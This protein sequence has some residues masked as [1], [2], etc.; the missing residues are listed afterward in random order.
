MNFL[1]HAVPYL[2]DDPVVAALTGLPDLL[3][4]VDRRVRVRRKMAVPFAQAEGVVGEVARGVMLHIDD[5]RWFHQTAAFVEL[6]MHLAVMLREHLPGDRGFRPS[7]LGHVLIEV[8]LDAMWLSDDPD[9]GRRY[10]DAVAAIDGPAVASAVGEL[11]GKPVPGLPDVIERFGREKFLLDYGDDIRL[12]R[13]MSGV[14]RR[15]GLEPLPDRL[16]VAYP[17]IR[18]RVAHQR[19]DLLNRSA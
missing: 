10:Y 2:D 18:R 15:V 8:I 4:V 3:S 12:H 13:R 6:N 19:A 16:I 7:F 11:T 5:D 9:L 1:C 14:M 17:E